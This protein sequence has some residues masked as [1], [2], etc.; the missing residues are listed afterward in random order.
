MPRRRL[1]DE[2]KVDNA[3]LTP[4]IDI[5]FQLLVF[6][7]VTM[8]MAKQQYEKLTLPVADKIDPGPTDPEALLV[9]VLKD[10]TVKISGK[11]Y[12]KPGMGD[13]NEMIEKLFEKRRSMPQYWGPS[14]DDTEVRYPLL[15]RADRST[16][17]EH[18]Q[19]VLMIASKCGRVTRLQL[20]AK[21]PK[22]K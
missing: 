22:A 9:N 12:W 19:K 21:K 16:S 4:L 15:I 17:F 13:R 3:N 11:T 7:M 5:V 20:G 8:N 1:P 18:I 10:G 6:F 2:Q 14:G